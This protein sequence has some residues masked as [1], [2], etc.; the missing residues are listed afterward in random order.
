MRKIWRD[1]LIFSAIAVSVPLFIL[2]LIHFTPRPPIVEMEHAREVLS[3]AEK[4]RA[5]TYS[6]KLFT[7]AKIFYDSAMVNWKKENKRFI[8]FRH[9]DK[10]AKFAGLCVKKASQASEN[11]LSTSSNLKTKL[12]QKIE[13]LNDLVNQI[14]G[15]FNTYPLTTEIRNRISNGKILLGEAEIVYN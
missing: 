4:S 14:D 5:D 11:S 2:L 8:Y 12:K 9:Y 13:S 10:V 15:L 3:E 6:K 7:E 1:V